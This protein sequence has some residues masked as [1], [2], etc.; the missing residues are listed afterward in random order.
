MHL[1]FYFISML[2]MDLK[3]KTTYSSVLYKPE[4]TYDIMPLWRYRQLNS[5]LY[6]NKRVLA[7]NLKVG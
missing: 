7:G 6:P 5:L 3:Y 4:C 1:K 2:K